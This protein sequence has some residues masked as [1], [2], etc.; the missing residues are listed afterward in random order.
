MFAVNSVIKRLLQKY[1][2]EDMSAASDGN[3]I[4][5]LHHLH[6]REHVFECY[7]MKVVRAALDELLVPNFSEVVWR[8]VDI[9]LMLMPVAESSTADDREPLGSSLAW[10]EIMPF[11]DLEDSGDDGE[12]EDESLFGSFMNPLRRIQTRLE[13]YV[14]EIRHT[15]TDIHIAMRVSETDTLHVR[16]NSA[17]Y[18][19]DKLTCDV[20]SVTLESFGGGE[21]GC[22]SA[23]AEE[24]A[25]LKALSVNCVAAEQITAEA[26]EASFHIAEH[27]LNA[28]MSFTSGVANKEDNTS[29]HT[30]SVSVKSV[31]LDSQWLPQISGSNLVAKASASVLKMSIDHT[32]ME[33]HGQVEK[34]RLRVRQGPAAETAFVTEAVTASSPFDEDTVFLFHAKRKPAPVARSD[35]MIAFVQNE[36]EASD[37]NVWISFASA[38]VTKLP[39]WNTEKIPAFPPSSNTAAQKVTVEVR[40][41]RVICAVAH[42]SNALQVRAD[43]LYVF[44]TRD[45]WSAKMSRVTIPHFLTLQGVHLAGKDT[46]RISCDVK[47]VCVEQG[48]HPFVLQIRDWYT[49]CFANDAEEASVDFI[50]RVNRV[51]AASVGRCLKQPWCMRNVEV[52]N[53][54]QNT[55]FICGRASIADWMSLTSCQVRVSSGGSVSVSVASVMIE[56]TPRTVQMLAAQLQV[57]SESNWGGTTPS[58]D[59]GKQQ[60]PAFAFDGDAVIHNYTAYRSLRADG[61]GVLEVRTPLSPS[62]KLKVCRMQINLLLDD[63]GVGGDGADSMEV[64]AE[65]VK[66]RWW[67][68]ESKVF[69]VSRVECIDRVAASKWNKALVLRNASVNSER[70]CHSV[71]CRERIVVSLDQHALNF[72]LEFC[73]AASPPPTTE[74]TTAT[75]TINTLHVTPLRMCINFKPHS[76]LSVPP[77]RNALVTI[78]HFECYDCRDAGEAASKFTHHVLSEAFTSTN[79]P[80]LLGGVKVL[81]APVN[82]L[83]S[84][85]QLLQPSSSCSLA[86]RTRKVLVSVLELTHAVNVGGAVATGSPSVYANQPRGINEG[87]R[88]ASET[89]R[90][91]ATAVVNFV[92]GET[93]HVDLFN[94]PFIVLRPITGPLSDVVNGV[95]NQLDSTRLEK[96]NDKYG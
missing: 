96:M 90:H 65:Q 27:V 54:T 28:L 47:E 89:F 71:Q 20:V 12:E 68:A 94:V 1:I 50:L 41:A 5:H 37:T 66:F 53:S 31:T 75:T 19:S 51:V 39:V 34:M 84:V 88:R 26:D 35:K 72:L 3:G 67:S 13:S 7:G 30:V 81:G 77:L 9:E 82:V 64:V 61:G 45:F 55:V 22:G 29:G 42:V 74:T 69:E 86:S 60:R 40:G 76:L 56:A 91:D 46:A 57:W 52:F 59:V 8:G 16:V 18:A 21:D 62:T 38:H 58:D 93:R 43:T 73:E 6:F 70:G 11:G 24:V 17:F 25:T 85:L 49:A 83:K 63:C 95:C 87:F 78:S 23:E 15:F 2:E 10:S 14:N 44:W 4:L 48:I 79:L 32:E 36:R 80:R 92:T 33:G